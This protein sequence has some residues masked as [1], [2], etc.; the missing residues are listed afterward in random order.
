MRMRTTMK[1]ATA[2]GPN[3]WGVW[4]RSAGG[5]AAWG[6]IDG[7]IFT[8]TVDEAI[9]LAKRWNDRGTMNSYAAQPYGWR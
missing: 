9:A 2:K 1:D 4:C 6:R 7:E 5:Q 3:V 8:G